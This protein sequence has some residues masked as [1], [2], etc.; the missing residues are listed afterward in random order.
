MRGRLGFAEEL[1]DLVVAGELAGTD[2][3]QRDGAIEADLACAIDDAHAA[4][5]DFLEELVVAEAARGLEMFGEARGSGER[6]RIFGRE[7]GIGRGGM[8]GGAAASRT[9]GERSIGLAAGAEGGRRPR[10]QGRSALL[11]PPCRL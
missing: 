8:G 4:L 6:H 11:S 9:G 3:L 7:S 2:H 1:S 10:I 5:G